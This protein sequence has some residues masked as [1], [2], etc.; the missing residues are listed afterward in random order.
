MVKAFVPWSKLL[1]HGRN[2]YHVPTLYKP[3]GNPTIVN[4]NAS[5]VKIYKA[6][7]RRVGFEKRKYFIAYTAPT[8]SVIYFL[9]SR[10]FSAFLK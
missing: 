5:A 6:A 9:A 4:Y 3:G 7:S 1:F 8:T 2:F 10:K